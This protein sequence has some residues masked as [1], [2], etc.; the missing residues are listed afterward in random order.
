M[1]PFSPDA[2]EWF[3]AIFFTKEHFTDQTA[4]ITPSVLT[5]LNYPSA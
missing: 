2:G 1:A 5:S 4:Q 3:R